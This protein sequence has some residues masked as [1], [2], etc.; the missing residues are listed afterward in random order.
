MRT[1]EQ[2]ARHKA[3]ALKSRREYV[4][5]KCSE[6][7]FT[8]P[9]GFGTHLRYCGRDYLPVFW[10]RVQKGERC[11]LWTGALQRDGYAHFT[12]NRKTISAHRFAYEKVI[13]PIPE[14]LDLLHSCDTRHCVN[15]AHLRPGTHQE[16]MDEA[17]GKLRHTY[18]EKNS[19]AKLNPEKVREIRRDYTGENAEELAKKYGVGPTTIYVAATRRTWKTVK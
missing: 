12:L 8:L 14:G 16:N 7:M 11:W 15:P 4:C 6:V 17:K 10:S 3:A 9:G 2:R 5:P 19:H 13:G 18:G 1:D